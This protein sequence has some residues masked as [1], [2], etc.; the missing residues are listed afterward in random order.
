M[1]KHR[2]EKK[3]LL[4]ATDIP[5]EDLYQNLRELNSINRLLGG[6]TISFWAL[7]KILSPSHPVSLIDIG[8]GGGDTLQNIAQLAKK[9]NFPITLYG[10]DMKP[11][12]IQ[13]AQSRNIQNNVRYF[14]DDYKNLFLH[15]PKVDIIHASL[16]CHHLS[17]EELLD[18]L[19]FSKHHKSTLIIN[20]L[21]RNAWAY[22]A[23]KFLTFC[24]SH[25]YLVKNDAP[26]SVARGFK[27]KEWKKLLE[28]AGIASY[29]LKNK[30]AFRHALIVYGNG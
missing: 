10:I 30:W 26:L 14:C 7:K 9:N 28:K 6:Y 25:S 11:V 13:Y 17:E 18:L 5:E 12:C 19:K 3:E 29:T 24:F 1:F 15:L 22:Y 21:E 16:F 8:C 27:K 4:D 23:I 2:S 20:D